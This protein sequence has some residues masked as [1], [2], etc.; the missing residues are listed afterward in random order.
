MEMLKHQR[1]RHRA[2]RR[3]R[4]QGTASN[5]CID[6]HAS[7][8]TGTRDRQRDDDFCAELPQLR[9]R[10]ARLLRVPPAA[11]PAARRRRRRRER[12]P[13]HERR[14]RPRRRAGSSAVAAAGAGRRRARA[15]HP[16]D[17]GRA[18]RAPPSAASSKVRWGMLIDTT[19]CAPD[20]NAC[21]TACDTENGIV[22]R[23]VADRSAQWI[24]KIEL[25]DMRDRPHALAADDVP[26]LRRA[27][28][29]R[30]LPD[31]RLVQ[32][33]RRH[34]AGRPPHL[35]RLP[36]L[37]DGLP[38][39]GALLR[40]RAADRPEAR[41]AARQGLRR[42]LHAVRAPRRP[43]P[44]RRPASRPAPTAGHNAMLF[45]DLNDPASEIAQRV[46]PMAT[47]PGAR[48]PEARPRRAL[49]GDLSDDR[50]RD[51]H[52][53]TNAQLLRAAGRSA[54][55]SRSSGS[56]PRTTWR[57]HGHVVTGM[58]NQ[59]VWGL[60]H[61][62]AIFLIVAASGVLNVASIGSVFGKTRLQAARAAVRP[63]VHRA[64]GRRPGGADARPRPAR[65]P[66]RR[67]DA[68]QLHVDVRAGTCSSTPACSAI[69]AVYLWT[70]MERRMNA[71]LASRPGSRPS[72]GASC[73]PPAPARSSASWSRARPTQSALLA[74]MFIVMSFAWGLAVFLVVQ[75]AMYAWNGAALPPT[76]L[77]RHEAACWAC[78]S[79][80]CC[81]FVARLSPD[82]PLLRAAGRLRALHP[83]STA[84]SIPLL[85]WGGYVVRRQRRCRCC[86][87]FHPRLR[88]RRRAAR[89]IAAGRRRRLRLALRL[90]HRRPG[91]SARDLPRHAASS[92]F[93]DGA[94]DRYAPSLPELLLGLGGV[95][96]AFL[97]T[98]VGVRVL[99]VPAAGRRL[100]RAARGARRRSRLTAADAARHAPL[101][102]LRRAQVLRQDHGQH[103]P[104]RGAARRAASRC[105]RSR[106]GR[107]TSTRCGWRRRAAARCR[108]LDFYLSRRDEIARRVRAARRRRRRLPGRR[109]QGPLRRPGARRQQQQRR[110]GASCS[111][112]RWCWCIDARGMTRG[113]APLILGYQAF[114]RDMRIAGVI[115]NHLGG[116]PPRSQAARRDRALH[117][118]AG[119]RRRAA[120]SAAGDR[121]APSR[122]DAE[123][124][125]RRR[126]AARSP[127]SARIVGGAGRPRPAAA[128]RRRPRRR[129]PC[130]ATPSRRRRRPPRRAV[131]IGIARDRAF[132]FYYADDLD[133]LRAAG[134]DAGAAS[135]PCATRSCPTSTACSSAAAFPRCFMRRARGQRRAA[136]DDPR[137]DRRRP[138]RLRR[139]RR[140]HVPG[141]LAR[142]WNGRSVRMV[143]AIPGDVVMHERP[144]GR[145]YVELER[146]ARLPVAGG[147]DGAG[148]E[149]ARARIPLFEP[150]EPARRT[151]ASPTRV[152]RGHGI[153]GR[154]DGIVVQQ[155]AGVVRA[156]A[157]RRRQRLGGALRRLRPRA[158]YRRG[159][160]TSSTCAGARPGSDGP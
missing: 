105:S 73:S 64:A 159:A 20:C 9:G 47:T 158:D 100:R 142:R 96:I 128:H 79:P 1:D 31:R 149:R 91:L 97:I 58:N 101:A 63:A 131:R 33:R 152:Q 127:R 23:Q 108:N 35:H 140:P 55:A 50:R 8:K 87:L 72:S 113:I 110:A 143:G 69:V 13:S 125:G 41:R 76:S 48:R 107:T 134:A 61:V 10:E 77:R 5:G 141:A 42:G 17:R 84:A 75:A 54:A 44:A 138:A 26:A 15:R 53:A 124:R 81:Y 16:P 49:P 6:C 137:R 109:Q 71:L 86:S 93:V 83:A 56:A 3:A 88:R 147:G 90:H 106:R 111:A 39:Q 156:P 78:S 28:L 154:R 32:A 157:Q 133:A 57:T 146:T 2:R 92:S 122:P 82:Q 129:S 70:M 29:R 74:P 52:A 21:V 118:R 153:D 114:D 99:R 130:P 160:A 46:A 24:R 102:H 120:R 60:P 136:R 132:G 30:R 12:R 123:Q 150:R 104:V 94:I 119:A 151:C 85:F 89:R 112:C 145:G 155:P 14:R 38:V 62:F 59:I 66:D 7:K 115:L 116:A 148:A 121:R 45:G 65:P 135:T 25:K 126:R 40:A 117:R 139:M 18:G 95:G 22:R 34:R 144:V 68:L 98:V 27:A 19:K 67:R 36:L 51:F 11:R 80:R 4:R 103:R 43:R 37:H